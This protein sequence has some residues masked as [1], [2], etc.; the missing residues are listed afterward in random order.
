MRDFCLDFPNPKRKRHEIQDS[1]ITIVSKDNEGFIIGEYLLNGP[2]CTMKK[3]A[4][5]QI[6]DDTKQ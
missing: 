5:E 3:N 6:V 1:E 4:V 2:N